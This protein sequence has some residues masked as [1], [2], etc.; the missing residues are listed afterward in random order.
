MEKRW[1][2]AVGPRERND[3]EHATWAASLE[4]RPGDG[5]ARGVGLRE[6]AVL[7]ERDHPLHTRA[8]LVPGQQLA[9]RRTKVAP[10]ICREALQHGQLLFVER[11]AAPLPE[12]GAQLGLGGEA[13]A[14]VDAAQRTV[15]QRQDVAA[16]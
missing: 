10:E 12:H 13:D 11:L 2:Q 14:V 4:G 9:Q 16:L 1:V 6:V 3:L 8:Y 5:G 7:E 15:S